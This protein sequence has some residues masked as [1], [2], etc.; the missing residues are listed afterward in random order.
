MTDADMATVVPLFKALAHEERLRVAA[1]TSERPRSPRDIA[2]G[3][4]LAPAVALRH[5]E[6]LRAAGL[7]EVDGE[8]EHAVYRFR[9]QPLLDAL[10][11]MRPEP[12]RPDLPENLEEFDRKVLRDF[13]ADGRLKT[14]PVQLKKR[15]AVLRFLARLFEP[16]RTY[17]E[18]IVNVTLAQ[19]HDD[20]ATLR[21]ALV[22][23]RLLARDHGVYWRV[24]EQ[25]AEGGD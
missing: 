5:V 19:Y 11:S 4:G 1:L 6:A 22:D 12:A 18:A 14:I 17:G 15:D 25:G 23:A 2:D 8:R 24:V 10:H 20:V 3:A 9:R 16:G 13:L 21:R 7:V